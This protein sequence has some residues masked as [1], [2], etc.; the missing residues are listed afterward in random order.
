[1]KFKEGQSTELFPRNWQTKILGFLNGFR[2]M[3]NNDSYVEVES[4]DP[5]LSCDDVLLLLKVI[6]R[7]DKEFIDK[8][9]LVSCKE[10]RDKIITYQKSYEKQLVDK[11][12]PDDDH[13]ISESAKD[14]NDSEEDLRSEMA[15]EEDEMYMQPVLIPIK[16]ESFEEASKE[17]NSIHTRLDALCSLRADSDTIIENIEKTLDTNEAKLKKIDTIEKSMLELPEII[18]KDIEDITKKIFKKRSNKMIDNLISAIV[19]LE[20]NVKGTADRNALKIQETI[21][22]LIISNNEHEK[23]IIK[24]QAEI[25]SLKNEKKVKKKTKRKK[26]K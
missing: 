17:I 14:A 15:R 4:F 9:S 13:H 18:G 26:T 25:E 2:V 10:I 16:V 3:S 23:I 24:M 20:N 7:D 21:N 19:E 11:F 12:I 8:E 1:M 6:N 5:V 22:S